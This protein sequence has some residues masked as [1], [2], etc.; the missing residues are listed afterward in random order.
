MA[1]LSNDQPDLLQQFSDIV[2][3]VEQTWKHMSSIRH[4]VK[5]FQTQLPHEM[6]KASRG[7]T[8]VIPKKVAK[9]KKVITKKKTG[10]TCGDCNEDCG[11]HYKIGGVSGRYYCEGCWDY[12]EQK[13]CV[14]ER[15]SH[16]GCDVCVAYRE[17]K[18]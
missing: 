10:I 16:R 4:S 9:P 2:E 7:C 5:T 17:G 14:H 3:Q 13:Y 11:N 8:I 12:I 15:Y 6:E 1:H 18:Y